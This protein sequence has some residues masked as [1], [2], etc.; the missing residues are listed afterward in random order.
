MRNYLTKYLTAFLLGFVLTQ[1]ALAGSSTISVTP[2]SGATYDVITDGSG[3]FVGMQGICD[4]SAAAYCA[5]VTSGHLLTTQTSIASGGV[6][7]GAFA[8]GALAS[9]SIAA[10]AMVDLLTMRGTVGAGTA[11]ADALI[12][13]AVYNS[14]P[15][16]VSNTQSAALQS[17]ANGFLKVN[18]AGGSLAVTGTFYQTTQPVSIASAQVA[19]GAIASGAYASGSVSSGA[20]ASGSLAAGS[21]V[22]LLTMRAPIGGTSSSPADVLVAGCQYLASAPTYTTSDSG[23]V[24]C[25]INGYPIVSVANSSI[26]VTGTFYQATQPVS[27]ASAQVASGAYASGS[28]ASGAFASGSLAAGSMVDLLTMRAAPGAALPADALLIGGS[29]GTD[30]RALLMS[31]TGQGHFIC[32]SGCG[33]SGGTS[34]TFGSAFPTTGTAIGLTNGTNM[35]AWSATSNYGTAPSAIAVPAVNAYITNTNANGSATSANSSPVVIASDQGAVAIK[36]ASASIAS[37]AVASGAIASGAIAAGAQVDLLT[38][39]GSASG[40]T[41]AADSILAGGVYNS[42]AP[43]LT[44]TQQAS[45][46]L[47]ASGNLDVNIKAG[48]GSG[49]TALAD[50]ATF[51]EAS[52]SFTPVGGEYV[53][54]GGASCT[55]GKGCTVQMTIDRMAYVNIGKVGG[56]ATGTAGSAGTGVLTV[57]GI[58]SMTPVLTNPGTIATWGLAAIGG[59]TGSP[60]NALA[61]GCQYNSSL[62]TFSTGDVGGAQCDSSGRLFVNVASATGLAQASS[63]SGQTGSLIMGAVTTG[64]ASY[65]TAQ[66]DPLSLDTAGGLRV[67]GEGTAGT[68]T[69]GVVT[70]QGVASMTPVLANPGTI[71]TWGLAAVGG[72]AAPT[73]A[74]VAGGVYNTTLPTVTATD[75]AALQID[76]FGRL[77]IAPRTVTSNTL[78]KGTTAAMTGTT[79][80]VVIAAVSSQRQY[81]TSVHC[82]NSSATATLV[83]LQD[84]S[85]GTTLD[86]LICPAGG[87]DERNNGGTPMIWT[88]A[89]NALYAADVTTGASVIV[90]ASGYSSAN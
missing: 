28:V 44:N 57:Q 58:A 9:G 27:I 36:A 53:S 13:G 8:S 5:T 63:T 66:T 14:T 3:N 34:S 46:Q 48:A 86:T 19:S 15:I 40:G 11:P 10:G 39:R 47:D 30:L 85:A 22:D 42:S 16:T 20:F 78:I 89:G 35:V 82:N 76:G 4:Q 18:V 23:A 83:S 51:T 49:G 61:A 43:T 32:D 29:D 7:S 72:A 65:T 2:G 79:S 80:T 64:N 52:T 74:L 50:G 31:S 6:A 38:M 77:V 81:I 33:G 55:T 71:A 17:D 68:A 87:G 54:G 67:A 75:A 37:G 59:T 88:T 45:L 56:A 12:G 21:M 25:T 1:P 26:A 84:G 41:A 62:P 24:Q 60:T 70:V 90:Q 69:G 73:N